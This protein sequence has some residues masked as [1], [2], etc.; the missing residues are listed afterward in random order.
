MDC[1]GVWL[2]RV[3]SNLDAICAMKKAIIDKKLSKFKLAQGS[4]NVLSY[5]RGT[6]FEHISIVNYGV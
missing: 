3:S 2:T 1:L 5:C 6:H 4:F